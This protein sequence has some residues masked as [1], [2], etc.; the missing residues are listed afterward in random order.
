MASMISDSPTIHHK[1]SYSIQSSVPS[2]IILQFDIITTT[3]SSEDSEATTHSRQATHVANS[4]T[5]FEDNNTARSSF[6]NV[7]IVSLSSNGSSYDKIAD[8]LPFDYRLGCSIDASDNLRHCIPQNG[9]IFRNDTACMEVDSLCGKPNE[10]EMESVCGDSLDTEEDISLIPEWINSG[11][12]F[13][14]L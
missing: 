9:S 2:E 8:I 1:T 13:W 4:L 5:V 11:E 6:N 3:G 14:T 12:D 10:W 7:E